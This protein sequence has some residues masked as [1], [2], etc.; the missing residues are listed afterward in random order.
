MIT[1][2]VCKFDFEV[3]QCGG[4]YSRTWQLVPIVD[5]SLTEEMFPDVEL[6]MLFVELEWVTSGSGINAVSKFEETVEW[7]FVDTIDD[8]VSLNEVSSTPPVLQRPCC[9][10]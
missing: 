2:K 1:Q 6:D 4:F 9:S 3:Q 5:D 10:A 7:N 8:P